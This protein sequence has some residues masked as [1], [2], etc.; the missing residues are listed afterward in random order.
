MHGRMLSMKE[1]DVIGYIRANSSH[2]LTAN[3]HL[4]RERVFQIGGSESALC[5]IAISLVA[6]DLCKPNRSAYRQGKR[7]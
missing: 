4:L 7:Q 5:M 2:A 3:I 6:Y 1:C